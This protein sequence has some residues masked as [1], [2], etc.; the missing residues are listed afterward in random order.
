MTF[1]YRKLP[2]G[3]TEQRQGFILQDIMEHT[4]QIRSR[5]AVS[6]IPSD[7]LVALSH[8]VSVCALTLC[9]SLF[10]CMYT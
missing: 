1:F 8:P 5:Y 2:S 9:K 6:H 3:S 4:L 7:W 10:G